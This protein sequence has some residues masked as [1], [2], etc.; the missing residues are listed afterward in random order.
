MG[1]TKISLYLTTKVKKEKKCRRLL[2]STCGYAYLLWSVAMVENL[3]ILEIFEK[4]SNLQ[5]KEYLTFVPHFYSGWVNGGWGLVA[6][7][8]G[9]F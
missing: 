8:F 2:E 5:I 3:N 4:S 7:S 9:Y 6:N 1:G